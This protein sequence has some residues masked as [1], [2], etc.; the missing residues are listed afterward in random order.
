MKRLSVTALCVQRL[1]AAT[2]L[3]AARAQAHLE[4]VRATLSASQFVRYEAWTVKSA[5][6]IA[7][8]ASHLSAEAQSK[9]ADSNPSAGAS[10]A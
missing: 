4:G 9:A 2:A 3:S 5:Q 10:T 1:R 8:A 6:R 7:K